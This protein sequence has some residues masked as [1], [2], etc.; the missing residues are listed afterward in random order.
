M[1]KDE[2]LYILDVRGLLIRRA[3]TAN[4]ENGIADSKGKLHATWKAGLTEFLHKELVPLFERVSPRRVIAVWDAGN[5]YRFGFY[6]EYKALRKARSASEPSELKKE[7]FALQEEAKRFMA[8]LGVKNVWVPGQEAD[9]VIALLCEKLSPTRQ[10]LI[11]TI[12][13]DLVQLADKN[14]HVMCRDQMYGESGSYLFK[15]NTLVNNVPVKLVG[16]YKAVVGDSSD[17]YRGVYGLGPKAWEKMFTEYGI[18]GMQQ[19]EECVQTG[20]WEDL[21]VAYKATQDKNLE[22]LLNKREE[23]A[24]SYR[25]AKLHPEVCYGG[26]AGEILKP[27]WKVRIPS[28][29]KISWLLQEIGAMDLLADFDKHLPVQTLYTMEDHEKLVTEMNG[30]AVG[31][32]VSYDFESYDTLKHQPYKIAAKNREFVDVLSQK[33]TGISWCHGDNYQKVGYA[34]FGH[35]DTEN[36][37]GGW[38][39][40]VLQCLGH[41]KTQV[42]QNANFELTVAKL[43]L[44]QELP[45]PFD[46]AIMSSYV[47]ENMDPHLKGL[48]KE[49]FNY[50][51]QTYQEVTQGSPMNELSAAHVLSY[52]CDD[53]LV[54]A[55][56]FDLFKIIMQLEDTWEFYQDNETQH[57]RDNVNTFI[58]GTK[59]DLP[60]LEAAQKEDAELVDNLTAK[61][62]R[63]LQDHVMQRDV[64]SIT[65]G[66][67]RLL[68]LYWETAELKHKQLPDEKILKQYE[69]LKK[70]DVFAKAGEIG[71]PI[72]EPTVPIFSTTK[73]IRK[74]MLNEER[75]KLWNK[76]WRGSYYVPYSEE[77][78]QTKFVPSA[79]NLTKVLRALGSSLTIEKEGKKWISDYRFDHEAEVDKDPK[80]KKF[81]SLLCEASHRLTPKKRS[82][83]EYEAL[84][85]VCLEALA[86][87]GDVKVATYGDALNFGSP[88]QMQQLLYGKLSLPVRRR[89]KVTTGSFRDTYNLPGAAVTGNKAILPALVHDV[90]EGDW[91]FPVLNSYLSINKAQQNNSLYYKS[92]PLWVSPKDGL[93]HPQLKNCGTVTRRPSGTSPNVLQVSSKDDAKIRRAFLPWQEEYVWVCLDFNGQELRLIASESKDPVMTDAYL[94]ADHKGPH[95]VTAG[96]IAELLLPRMG[97]PELNRSITYEEYKAWSTGEDKKL[98]AALKEIRNKYGKAT[99]FTVTYGGGPSTLAENLIIELPLA[100][101]IMSSIMSLYARIEP[102]QRE[103]AEYARIHGYVKT[104][105]GNRRH[106]SD[107]IYSEDLKLRSRAE[108][109]ACNMP[110]QGCAADILKIVLSMVARKNLAEKY[111]LRSTMPIYDELASCVPKAAAADYAMEMAEI[112][113]ITPPGHAIPMEAELEIG[114]ASWGTKQEVALDHGAITEFLTTAK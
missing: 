24:L 67:T 19:I 11:K 39:T 89:G 53:S 72:K 70:V 6:P 44:D 43:D 18:D 9:D 56:L 71:G 110:A 27:K 91:R 96:R 95:T 32:F 73:E 74:F 98:A 86:S 14:I 66:A 25:L 85:A 77:V 76:A 65:P 10:L 80:V 34:S 84:E 106:V 108:R 114:V 62:R 26:R 2:A 81:F 28:R 93:I 101:Q 1:N 97:Y 46:T 104:A 94:G 69:A 23:F 54:T 31:S 59:I 49:W 52:G 13:A 17:G 88:D 60:F 5:E 58:H 90:Q 99:N 38:S 40:Y 21:E 20:S 78:E 64:A 22:T 16:L 107:N 63:S 36:L 75:T 83:A 4:T 33:I 102:W 79:N 50:S 41:S 51:Q 8:Y 111:K 87:V 57:V 30:V 112:M 109:Q 47:D 7:R 15:I 55:H 82:G 48:A 103:V 37:I 12:D 100:E 35:A 45:L 113:A 29:E 92:Y 61:I 105:Y 42:V 3:S 68:D